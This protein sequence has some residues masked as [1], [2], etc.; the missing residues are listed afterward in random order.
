MAATIQTEIDVGHARSWL[1]MLGFDPSG[2]S[3]RLNLIDLSADSS[4]GFS[5][6]SNQ[7]TKLPCP[8]MLSHAMREACR[9][10]E[11]GVC[12]YLHGKGGSLN[13][14][15]KDAQGV[16]LMM[17]ACEGGSLDVAKWL[18]E[19]GASEDI[20]T[21]TNCGSSP[22]Y[23]AC[24]RGRLKMAKWLYGVGAKDD[25][26]STDCMGV[27]P[28]GWANFEG[29]LDVA[30]WLISKSAA[31]DDNGHVSPFILNRDVPQYRRPEMVHLLEEAIKKRDIFASNILVSTT[32]GDPFA[33]TTNENKNQ[34]LS[35]FARLSGHESTLIALIAD[36]IG[37]VRG[38]GLRNIR[39]A[40]R[41]LSQ[42][43]RELPRLT[44]LQSFTFPRNPY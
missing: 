7:K 25:I 9:Q 22:M 12:I 26:C 5:S 13:I 10:G 6:R 29:H 38:R 3:S 28:L 1:K 30:L 33:E 4:A 11:L 40:F 27:S 18:F 19:V 32:L 34:L 23:A 16:T 43:P 24:S 15:E 21:K 42:E 17:N 31:N 41:F 44:A 35:D 20:R 36:F 37:I 2:A 39:E 14:R 8:I